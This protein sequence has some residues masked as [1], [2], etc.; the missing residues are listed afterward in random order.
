MMPLGLLWRPYFS[1]LTIFLAAAVLAILA[2]VTYARTM[3]VQPGRST[4][5]LAM[6]LALLVVLVLFL[7]GPSFLPQTTR[8][9]GKPTLTILTD[10]SGSMQ[11]PDAAATP[12]LSYVVQHWLTPRNCKRWTST[13]TCISK[14]SISGIDRPR[15][16][17]C[18]SRSPKSPSAGKRMWC[19]ACAMRS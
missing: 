7:M 11:T 6:R 5:L 2:I 19:R 8:Q 18:R 17:R 4:A 16:R 14:R 15:S 12:R 1:P 9:A 13:T 3:H 10:T